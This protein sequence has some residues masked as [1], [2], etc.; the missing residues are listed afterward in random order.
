MDLRLVAERQRDLVLAG[1]Q[2]LPGER[3]DLE[4]MRGTVGRLTDCASRSAAMVAPGRASSLAPE[5]GD[6]AGR[7]DHRQPVLQAVPGW[8]QGLPQGTGPRE[9]GNEKRGYEFLDSAPAEP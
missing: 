8:P 9:P 6:D 7:Q 4:G 2:H 5:V 3:L 1:P